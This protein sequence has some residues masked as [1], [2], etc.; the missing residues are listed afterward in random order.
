MALHTEGGESLYISSEEL[1]HALI[2]QGLS[3]NTLL[4]HYVNTIIIIITDHA[5]STFLHFSGA[6]FWLGHSLSLLHTGDHFS[7]GEV[8]E[9]EGGW[10]KTIV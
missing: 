1:Q 2:L 7:V 6:V 8:V 3:Y 4:S 10:R 5:V 9:W